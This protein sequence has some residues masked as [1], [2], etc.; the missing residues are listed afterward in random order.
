MVNK[1]TEIPIGKDLKEKGLDKYTM[2][3]SNILYG[4]YL[5]LWLPSELIFGRRA[6]AIARNKLNKKL[7]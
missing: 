1:I 6:C 2:Y 7:K 5:V 4:L 3:T